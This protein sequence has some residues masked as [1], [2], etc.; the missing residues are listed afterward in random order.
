MRR[1]VV[2][3]DDLAIDWSQPS[4]F[5]R[6][7]PALLPN[8]PERKPRS[9]RRNQKGQ[10]AA[11]SAA[12]F[13]IQPCESFAATVPAAAAAV[14]VSDGFDAMSPWPDDD[15]RSLRGL[16]A[17]LRCAAR[18]ELPP[19]CAAAVRGKCTADVTAGAA[20]APLAK[21]RGVRD[22]R[23]VCAVRFT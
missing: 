9:R 1:S 20:V 10:Q 16:C 13:L 5:R 23:L 21:P 8:T 11:P 15:V 12:A 22:R 14:P 2:A 6:A 17:A 3:Q 19:H 7:T 4:A 18:L